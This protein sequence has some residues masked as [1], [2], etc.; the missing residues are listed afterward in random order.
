[1]EP[2]VMAT[3]PPPTPAFPMWPQATVPTFPGSTM[4]HKPAAQP[5]TPAPAATPAATPAA[6][7]AAR[8]AASRP[9]ASTP[10]NSNAREPIDG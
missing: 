7:P 4:T 9:P 10:S 1:L 6:R 2:S 5:A 3:L 8:P